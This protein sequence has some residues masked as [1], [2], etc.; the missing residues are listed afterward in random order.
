MDHDEHRLTNDLC[1][2]EYRILFI[3]HWFT[4]IS[5]VVLINLLAYLF[6][7]DYLLPLNCFIFFLPPDGFLFAYE[8][9]FLFMVVAPF[10]IVLYFMC[11]V[12]LPLVLMNQTCWLLD[13]V[14]I[15][16][17]QMNADLKLE[18]D[19]TDQERAEKFNGHLKKFIERCEKVVEW[20]NE[21]QDLLYWNFNVEFQIQAVILCLFVYFLSSNFFASYIVLNTFLVCLVQLFIFCW[22]GSRVTS[23]YDCL[24]FEVSKNW[25]L[26]QPKQRKALQMV[27]HWTQNMNGFTGTFKDV[28]METFQVVRHD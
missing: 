6:P 4:G 27:L 17:E 3:S 22:M 25:Y 11:Y 20:R 26:L 13:M 1:K 9:N 8:L 2:R 15:T 19:I 14:L 7:N 28:S 21:V 10:F 24:S 18:D 23:R 12:P 16:A 5:G